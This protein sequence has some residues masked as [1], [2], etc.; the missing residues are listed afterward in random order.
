MKKYVTKLADHYF[1]VGF[2]RNLI[3]IFYFVNAQGVVFHFN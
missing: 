1:I 3:L 2:K